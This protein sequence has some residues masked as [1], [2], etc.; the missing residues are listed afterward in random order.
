MKSALHRC[1]ERA[2]HRRFTE[3]YEHEYWDIALRDFGLFIAAV[4]LFL[5]ATQY[6]RRTGHETALAA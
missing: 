3:Y 2:R 4:S 1:A 6:A 5:L